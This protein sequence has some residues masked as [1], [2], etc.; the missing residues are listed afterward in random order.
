MS[1]YLFL[2]EHEF[3]GQEQRLITNG[4]EEEKNERNACRQTHVFI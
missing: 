2:D 3:Q 4:K 1:I